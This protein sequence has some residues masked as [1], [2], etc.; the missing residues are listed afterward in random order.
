VKPSCASD[1][2]NGVTGTVGGAEGNETMNSFRFRLVERLAAA[3]ALCALA[4][5]A[6]GCDAAS[7]SSAPSVGVAEQPL[8]GAD[9]L[10][11][12]GLVCPGDTDD[13]GVKLTGIVEGNAAISGVTSVDAF[14]ASVIKFQGAATGV[15]GGI[16]G[17][18]D[19]IRGDF[20]I[21]ADADLKAQLMAQIKANLEGD[22]KVDSEPARHR[23][24]AMRRSIRASS[25]SNARAVAT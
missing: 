21:A 19:A 24:A 5:S 7:A 23:R 13:H 17:Q 18:L 20:G 16:K 11:Q 4:T 1:F 9:L 15:T 6:A 10:K 8:T 25:R 12:C 2:A 3:T 22:L 14:F